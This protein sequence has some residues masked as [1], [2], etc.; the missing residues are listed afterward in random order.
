MVWNLI[1]K[2]KHIFF[3]RRICSVK[4]TFQW[5]KLAIILF[6]NALTPLFNVRWHAC[7]TPACNSFQQSSMP[8]TPEPHV[9]GPRVTLHTH[10]R[11]HTSQY[12]LM[13]CILKRNMCVALWHE[14]WLHARQQVRN[15]T[16]MLWQRDAFSPVCGTLKHR[17]SVECECNVQ[18]ATFA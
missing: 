6:Y 18:R 5:I 10:T 9:S 11:T 16:Q 3:K 15:A 7:N 1:Y 12:P 4:K 14:L 13:N 17:H 8:P 2:F